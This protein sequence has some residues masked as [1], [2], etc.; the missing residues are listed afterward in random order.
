MI[1]CIQLYY[2]TIIGIITHKETSRSSQQYNSIKKEILGVEQVKMFGK[3]K[4]KEEHARASI[5]YIADLFADV[6]YGEHN[7][8]KRYVPYDSFTE[9]FEEYEHY[10]KYDNADIRVESERVTCAKETFR[11][12]FQSLKDKVKLRTAKGAF[13]TCCVCNNLN[14]CIKNS[15]GEW[16]RKMEAIHSKDKLGNPVSMYLEI[17]GFTEFKTKSPIQSSK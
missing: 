7:I 5:E 16:T 14:D 6:G 17:D 9:L 11:K 10:H 15:S 4:N 1:S 3:A 2:I 12:A 13:E 8:N